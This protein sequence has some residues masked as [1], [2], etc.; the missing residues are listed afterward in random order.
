MTNDGQ[1]RH[2][3]SNLSPTKSQRSKLN[4]S[5]A[6]RSTQETLEGVAKFLERAANTF[7]WEIPFSCYVLVVLFFVI[8]IVLYFVPLR[9]LLSVWGTNKVRFYFHRA[10][11]ET[12]PPR[13]KTAVH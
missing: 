5:S 6:I 1:I 3:N 13:T 4:P 8:T 9:L 12:R 11:E 2:Q 7:S 10:F